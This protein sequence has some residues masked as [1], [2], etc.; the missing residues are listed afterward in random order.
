[1]S[2]LRS[3]VI[4]GRKGYTVNGYAIAKNGDK[5]NQAD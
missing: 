1:M 5:Y 2:D 4:T 3:A